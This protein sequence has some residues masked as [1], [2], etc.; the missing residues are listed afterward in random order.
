MCQMHYK[1]H[2]TIAYHQTLIHQL[3]EI[4]MMVTWIDWIVVTCML[5]HILH[6]LIKIQQFKNFLQN[7]ILRLME[8][9]WPR[10]VV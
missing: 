1:L 6:F 7:K 10:I 3:F 2:G 4:L 5:G 8:V 9:M